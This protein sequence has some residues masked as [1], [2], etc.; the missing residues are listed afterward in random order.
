MNGGTRATIGIFGALTVCRANAAHA[1]PSSDPCSLLT[2]AQVATALGVPVTV[3]K[4]GS[5]ATHCHWEQTGKNGQTLVDAHLMLESV[6][7]YDT[8][9]NMMGMSGKV[10]KVAI[11]GVGDDAYY[12]VSARRDAP[13]FVKKGNAAFRIA[14][15][16]KGWAAEDI[17]AKEKA[18]ALALLSK[19]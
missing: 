12:L 15:D 11:S 4:V 16:G 6:K 13:L 8:A 18:F 2:E 9:K 14:V 1:A 7:A 10:T 3:T 5:D 19:L 17:K